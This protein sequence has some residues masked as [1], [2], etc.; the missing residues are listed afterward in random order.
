MKPTLFYIYDALCGWCYGFSP[1]VSELESKY[2]DDFNFRVLSGGMVTGD[3]VSTLEK[4]SSF[5]I[6]SFRNVEEKTNVQ[7]GPEFIKKLEADSQE[8]YSS[9]PAAMAMAH[10]RTLL[11]QK[12]VAFASRIQNAIYYQGWP[13]AN[14]ETYANCAADFDLDR[15]AFLKDIQKEELHKLVQRE[16]EVVANWGIKGFPSLILQKGEKAYVLSRG[17]NTLENI[18]KTI[19]LIEAELK[20]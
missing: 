13:P 17:Y 7:F 15:A 6:D 20:A 5:I 1:V 4:V 19:A 9:E 10:F 12:E 11:P 14:W 2:N 18:E 3:R 16:F 8:L